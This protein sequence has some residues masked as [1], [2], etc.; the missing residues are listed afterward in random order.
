MDIILD[1]FNEP[2]NR[3]LIMTVLTLLIGYILRGVL[4]RIIH[5]NM[6]DMKTFYKTKQIITY[7]YFAVIILLLIAIWTQ[8]NSISTYLGLASA[9]IAIA[10]SDLL[11]NIAAWLFI[12]FRKP[13]TVGDRIEINGTAGDVIDQRLFQFTVMEIGNWVEADQST[14]RMVHVPN[15]SVFKHPLFNYNSGFQYIWNEV[16]VLLTF[17][18][19]YKKAKVLF[20]EIA[21]KHSLQQTSKME[22]ELKEA[23]KKYMIYYNK[24]TPIIY[25]DV[26]DSGILLSIRYLCAHQNRRNTTQAIWEDILSVTEV[27]DDVTLAYNTYRVVK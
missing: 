3:N 4:I 14:G 17:E 18:S 13:F 21:E 6:K 23:S 25:T 22:E 24:L 5:K 11:I 9:G 12:M 1:F 19:D 2:G 26:K 8:A 7:V 10:L 16:H 15:S 20:Q 27:H